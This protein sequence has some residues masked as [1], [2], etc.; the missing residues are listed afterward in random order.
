MPSALPS[1][2]YEDANYWANETKLNVWHFSLYNSVPNEDIPKIFHKLNSRL[3]LKLSQ[4]E[5]E[6]RF[7]FR[8]R[9]VSA[10]LITDLL[11]SGQ[12]HYICP[13]YR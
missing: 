9:Y 4:E 7:Y 3:R 6:G 11:I 13:Q 2:A 8:L 12:R 10:E 1:W 5:E